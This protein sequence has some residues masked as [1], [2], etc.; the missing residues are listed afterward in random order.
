MS[1]KQSY[2]FL[3]VGEDLCFLIIEKAKHIYKKIINTSYKNDD[4]FI[5]LWFI[6]ELNL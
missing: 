1:V 3:S 5:T 4:F 6:Y 2:C